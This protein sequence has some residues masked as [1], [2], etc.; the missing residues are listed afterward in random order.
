MKKPKLL[1]IMQLP[2]P[3]HGASLQNKLIADNPML[4]SAYQVDLINLQFNPSFQTIGRFGLYK[5]LKSGGYLLKIFFKLFFNRYKLTVF[6]LSTQGYAL[7]RDLI[8]CRCI[9]LFHVPL[10]L[11]LHGYGYRQISRKPLIKMLGSCFRNSYVIQHSPLLFEDIKP[12][13]HLKQVYFIANGILEELT[14]AEVPNLLQERKSQK[15]IPIVLFLSAIDPNKGFD[16]L[17][18]AAALLK[19]EKTPPF[20]LVFAGYFA[21]ATTEKHF[22]QLVNDLK[23]ADIVEYAGFVSGQNKK[24]WLSQSAMLVFPTL[25][26]AFGNVIVE[27][28][29]FALPVIASAE[30]SIPEIIEN[31]Y[32][33]YLCRK[34]N[35][36][37]FAEKIKLLL[38]N[39]DLRQSLGENG[40]KKYLQFYTLTRYHENFAKTIE[41]IAARH[42]SQ[43]KMVESEPID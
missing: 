15:K 26:E 10:V 30:G 38:E 9:R 42:T 3:T 17:L 14:T 2:P 27:A 35:S 43:R 12:W 34:G 24:H 28:M 11:H 36:A 22:Y 32:T 4:K 25:R 1:L 37:E 19:K 29:Q 21:N 31:N 18:K 5:L 41:K 33:G 8:Y 39:P 20:R 23:L 16:I 40:R 6:T 13:V 7:I